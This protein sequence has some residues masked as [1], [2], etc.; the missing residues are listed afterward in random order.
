MRANLA[1]R[2]PGMLEQWERDELY[3]TIREVS[4]GRPK[5][6]LPDGPPYANGSIHMGHAV[7]KVLKDI[8]V[9]FHTLDGR[10]APYV[11]GWD[12]HGLPIEHQVE[13]K[14]GRFDDMLE[15]RQACREYAMKQVEQQRRDFR[16]LG[17]LGD[18]DRPYLTMAPR[19]E[20]E[21]LRA[22]AAIIANGH[23]YKGYKPV[24]WCL[25]CRS[26]LAE[27]EVEYQDKTSPSIDVRFPFADEKKFAAVW[28]P[29]DLGEGTLSVPIW[30]TTPWTLPGNQAVAIHPEFSYTLV[31]CEVD[32]SR[33]RL[34]VATDLLQSF[35]QRVDAESVAV[36]GERRGAVFGGLKLRH[37][38]YDRPSPVILA[39]HVTLEAGTGA[40]H[41]APGHGQ[42]DFA[43]GVAN[44]LPLDNPVGSD[45]CFLPDVP[46][47]AGEHVLKAN[48]HVIEVLQQHGA[49][50]HLEKYPHSYPHCW[51]HKSPLIFRATPQWFISMDEKGLRATALEEIRKVRWTPDWAQQRIEAMVEGRPDWCISRQRAWGVP[52]AVFAHRQT[53]DLHPRTVEILEQLAARIGEDGPDSFAVWQAADAAELIGDDADEYEKVTDTMDVWFDSGCSHFCTPPAFPQLEFPADLYLEG[54]DQHRGWFQSSLLTSVAINGHAP[55]R[56]VL[57]H[58]FAVDEGGRKMSKSIGNVIEPQK[59]VGTLGADILRLWVAAADFSGEINVS[60]EILRRLSDSYRRMRNTTR[61]LLGNLHGYDATSD[62]VPVGEMLALDRWALDTA[63]KLQEEILQAYRDYEF[64]LIYQKVHNFCAVD[65]GRFYLD[66]IKDRLYTMPAGSRGRRSA[67]TAMF[68]IAEAMVRWLAPVLSFTAEEVWQAL[69]QPRSGERDMSVLLSQWHAIPSGDEHELDWPALIAV[70]DAVNRELERERERGELGSALAAEVDLYC[71][72]PLHDALAQLG[73]ELRFLLIT[74]EAKAHAAADRP[75]DA[76]AIEDGLWMQVTVSQHAK[77]QRC[78]HRRADVGSSQAHPEI[79]GRCIDNIDGDGEARRWV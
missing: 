79:C 5:F 41:T 19:Y 10:D 9:K 51:R 47:F 39:D 65:M 26:A 15:L 67:Q 32:G 1:Q 60:D 30:T 38:F 66:I 78:W 22:L 14:H 34:L 21:Q 29:G 40:V 56:G 28:G 16:R 77:C 45:G 36:L 69:P 6:M 74:S 4:R 58:G 52:I 12:C 75:A 7:N 62:E 33:E 13:R 71:E 42:E 53:N 25:D 27:A 61:F 63:A 76:I 48:D 73:D 70:R 20:A 24:H 37:P 44:D 11:P 31:Q 50:L 59:I 43:A 23:V 3:Q 2:E 57:T 46:L 17:V 72:A 54:S 64:H 68:H 18:W 35:L 8:I 49:L 55:Y